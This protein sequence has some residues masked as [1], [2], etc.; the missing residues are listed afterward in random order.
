MKKLTTMLIGM[1]M[2]MCMGVAQA[3]SYTIK[4]GDTL[5]AIAY[6]NKTT[7]E[8]LL[9][10]NAQISNPN[11]IYAGHTLT[12][13][14]EAT[15]AA[16]S[17]ARSI[18][19]IA[20][21]PKPTQDVREVKTSSTQ[22]NPVAAIARLHY[23]QHIAE[24][25]TATVEKS[26]EAPVIWTEGHTQQVFTVNNESKEYFTFAYAENCVF[27]KQEGSLPPEIPKFTAEAALTSPPLVHTDQPIYAEL[28]PSP[29]IGP[30]EVQATARPGL[31]YLIRYFPKC[32][33]AQCAEEVQ[34]SHTILRE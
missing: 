19:R 31:I 21:H 25:L 5:S 22:C 20:A 16:V 3:A 30:G 15:V 11:K 32:M 18:P 27:A 7:V 9:G 4:S 8:S 33:G 12:I 28:Q 1:F 6:R 23:P 14:R 29:T 13:S 24:Q 2:L 17:E 34:G 10:L 26:L